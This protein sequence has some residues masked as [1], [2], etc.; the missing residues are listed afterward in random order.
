MQL[1]ET[2]APNAI[3]CWKYGKEFAEKEDE[4]GT[5]FGACFALVILVQ[6]YEATYCPKL[7]PGPETDQ[8]IQCCFDHAADIRRTAIHRAELSA[9]RGRL[10]LRHNGETLRNERRTHQDTKALQNLSSF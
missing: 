3:N 10:A 4:H 8:P 9:H 2:R 5:F 6:G 1:A 7:G